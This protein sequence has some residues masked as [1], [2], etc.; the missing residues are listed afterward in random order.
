MQPASAISRANKLCG[1]MKLSSFMNGIVRYGC[2][3]QQ[4]MDSLPL[5][6]TFQSY[7]NSY[8]YWAPLE[9]LGEALQQ[10]REKQD[11]AFKGAVEGGG[12]WERG[13]PATPLWGTGAASL[14]R[15]AAAAEPCGSIAAAHPCARRGHRSPADAG[16]AAAPGPPRGGR[17]GGPRPR[18][19]PASSR[20]RRRP[21]PRRPPHLSRPPLSGS[22]RAV[23]RPPPAPA[24]A[25]FS[26]ELGMPPM[27]PPPPPRRGR[28]AGGAGDVGSFPESQ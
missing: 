1:S 10:E 3:P 17:A 21:R 22:P 16:A 11:W 2:L 20:S 13:H 18:R 26:R 5:E 27:P 19:L 7:A 4:G 24:P 9:I 12:M 23:W 6:A 28:H 15:V 25:R 8:D 14:S